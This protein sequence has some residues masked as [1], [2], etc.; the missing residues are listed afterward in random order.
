MKKENLKNLNIADWEETFIKLGLKK[1]A[2]NQ[3]FQWIFSR[4][5]FDFEEMM[6]RTPAGGELP[7]ASAATVD[8]GRAYTSIKRV[9]GRRVTSVEADIA[10]PGGGNELQLGADKVPL[11]DR[12]PLGQ[13]AQDP[14]LYTKLFGSHRP[15]QGI[16]FLALEHF[17][18]LS[19]PTRLVDMRRQVWDQKD[20]VRGL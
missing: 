4:S 17:P 18:T 5:V 9:D 12:V 7:L 3:I 14:R 20:W 6:I 1:Y 8:W 10:W 13:E 2:V 16:Q 15:G 19:V 11:F